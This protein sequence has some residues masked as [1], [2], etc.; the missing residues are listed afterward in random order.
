M[1]NVI[2]GLFGNFLATFLPGKSDVIGAAF[3]VWAFVAFFILR[4]VW[5]R[6]NAG[7]GRSILFIFATSILLFVA[8]IPTFWLAK[9]IDKEFRGSPLAKTTLPGFSAQLILEIRDVAELRRQYIFQ[10]VTPESA[11]ADFY[12][13]PNDQF[14]F[15][16]TDT[17]GDVYPLYLPIGIFG[18]PIYQRI[19]LVCEVGVSSNQTFLRVVVDGNEI[20]E[21]TLSLRVDLG[22]RD[23]SKATMGANIEGKQNSAFTV[24]SWSFGHVTLTDRELSGMRSALLT[25]I[26]TV[27]HGT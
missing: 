13:S 11:H 26:Q 20:A 24:L 10:H 22:S 17:K 2:E 25:Y 27:Q 21:Q 5:R 1:G 18:V 19:F 8:L 15:S 9:F 14:V 7:M 3:T 6:Q 16:I 4:G 12:L 23:W